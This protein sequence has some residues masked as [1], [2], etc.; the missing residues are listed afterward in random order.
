MI[1]VIY[2]NFDPV[3][4]CPGTASTPMAVRLLPPS[5]LALARLLGLLWQAVKHDEVLML[6]V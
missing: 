5:E 4:P 1:G 2:V 6:D 3:C